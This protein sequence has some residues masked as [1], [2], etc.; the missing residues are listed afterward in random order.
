MAKKK[1]PKASSFE[2]PQMERNIPI[3]R[4]H[5]LTTKQ[6]TILQTI[7]DEKTGIVIIDGPAG[8]SKT[9]LAIYAALQELNN[10]G[11]SL[12]Y[13]RSVVENSARRI[14]H[15]PGTLHEKFCPFT[16]PLYDKLE[17]FICAQDIQYLRENELIDAKPIN[18]LRGADWR[19]KFVVIDEAQNMTKE[20]LLTAMTRANEGTKIILC[21]DTMQLDIKDSGFSE[22]CQKFADKQSL[23]MGIYQF[24]FDETDIVR[25][26]LVR[27]IVTK[28][29]EN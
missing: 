24:S 8:T 4:K 6:Q 13:L 20:E 25:S 22:V 11:T 7:L 9:Y 29:K 28:F 17:E 23:K 15:L 1:A 2:I 19:Y 21:G 5:K 18:Y 12:L 16:A 3:E 26:P 14:G 27:F 10:R